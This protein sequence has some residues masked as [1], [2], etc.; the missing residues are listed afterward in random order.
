MCG[1]SGIYAK[2]G[3]VDKELIKTMTETMFHR[4]P[5]EDGYLFRSNI[6]MGM[7]RLSIIDI[8]G[9]HQPIFNEDGSI[10]VICNGQ[11]YNYI[12]LRKELLSRGHRLQ[13]KSDIEV[14]VH[15]YEELGEKCFNLFNGMFAIAIWDGRKNKL[16]LARDRLGIKP[17]Y[18]YEDPKYFAF[19]S[20]IK[21]LLRCPFIR[22]EPDL[23]SISE[24]FTLMY[25]R[26]PRSPFKSIFKLL[27]G[28]Y[29]SYYEGQTEVI[30]YWNL[31]DYCIVKQISQEE[32][33]ENILN[34]L[35]DSVRLRLRSDVP[36]GAFL[37]GGIDSSAM[38]AFAAK[39]SKNPLQ[40]FTVD[41]TG[42]EFKEMV[43]A[44]QVSQIFHTDHHEIVVSVNDMIQDLPKLVWYLDEPNADSAIVP[45]YLVSKFAASNLRVILCGLGG[46]ELFGGYHRYF[47][48]LPI[49]HFYRAL[50]QV[51]IKKIS[52]SFFR[53]FSKSIANRLEWNMKS[54]SKRYLDKVTIFH[55]NEKQQILIG[56]HF[57]E[58]NFENEFTNYP[59][60]DHINQLLFVDA[61]TYLPDDILALTDRMSMAVSLETR[62]PFLDYR[63]VEFCAS[64]A[65]YFKVDQMRR[66]WKIIL[67]K[68]F[69]KILP[70]EIITRPKWGFGA[71]ISAWMDQG[72]DLVVKDLYYN[73]EAVKIGLINQSGALEYI[74]RAVKLRSKVSFNQKL[75]TLLV[76]EVWCRVF[77]GENAGEK[78]T[79]TLNDL[80]N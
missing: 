35:Q 39:E 52:P 62:V 32:A 30:K 51:L 36:V 16:I 72:L 69:A 65:G 34:L 76:L 67:K 61:L 25:I 5:I 2:K 15:W 47:D 73:S 53:V 78:P 10:G 75:W 24:Y 19:A 6:G 37:S 11:I 23:E 29:L 27:P 22:K 50:P 13:T 42:K 1:I 40:T 57:L 31:A 9:G 46:D 18:Y 60:G 38:V 26:A 77:F 28:H 71:P 59:G 74:D 63:L 45:T 54:N 79:F 12:E 49:E 14:I 4:G 56:S 21:A 17:L 3:I 43:Y 44:R 80:R 8:E 58:S 70:Q 48:G 7:R 20:E 55:S 68:A 64:L 66:R 33:I 41:F